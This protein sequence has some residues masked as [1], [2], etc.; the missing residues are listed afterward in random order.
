MKA[1][2]VERED[3]VIS[4]WGLCLSQSRKKEGVG[5]DLC[6]A[7]LGGEGWQI[8]GYKVNK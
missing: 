8:L 1:V 2:E 4:R 3:E 6:E 7:V 5:E